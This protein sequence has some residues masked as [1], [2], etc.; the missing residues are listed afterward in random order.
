MVGPSLEAARVR[1]LFHYCPDT[2][3]FTRRVGR[4]GGRNTHVGAT[5]GSMGKDGY[6]YIRYDK[7][8]HLAHRWAWLYVYGEW[9]VNEVDHLNGIKDDNRICNL[10][11]A[12]RGQNRANS[13]VNKN[14]KLGIK[15]VYYRG[16][17]KAFS[18]TIRANKKS[19][20]LGY[21]KSAEAASEAYATA[22][23]RLHGAFAR[24]L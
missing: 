11:L 12:S 2:G 18:A 3:V 22:A 24:L 1:E 15:G 21:F 16:D 13:R 10:R 6:R 17:K 20:H 7:K 8:L 19:Y 9:P 4:P 14:N 23:S 5:V